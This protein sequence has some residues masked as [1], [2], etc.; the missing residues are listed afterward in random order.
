MNEEEKKKIIEILK[1]VKDP[2]TG[3][4]I[5]TLGLVDGFTVEENL[6]KIFVNFQVNTPACFFCKTI[7]WKIIEDLSNRIVEEFEKEGYYNVRVVEAIN[8]RIFY[9]ISTLKT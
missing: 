8:P 5:V 3:M 6:T 2:E 9:K 1:R 7:A 4:D